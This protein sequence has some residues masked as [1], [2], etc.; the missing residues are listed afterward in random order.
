ML[1]AQIPSWET[2]SATEAFLPVA[3]ALRNRRS[4]WGLRFQE[5]DLYTPEAHRQCGGAQIDLAFGRN[6]GRR[7]GTF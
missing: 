5:V 2:Y 1:Q 4:H 7:A 6:R 3:E